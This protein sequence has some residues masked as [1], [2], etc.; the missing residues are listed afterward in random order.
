VF[1]DEKKI[2]KEQNL[3]KSLDKKRKNSK[4]KIREKEHITN[5]R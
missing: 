1:L 2:S 3:K 4:R 5:T